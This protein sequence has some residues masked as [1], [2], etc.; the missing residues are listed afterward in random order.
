METIIERSSMNKKLAILAASGWILSAVLALEL[1][2][3][4]ADFKSAY[5]ELRSRDEIF[6]TAKQIVT[7]IKFQEI[8]DNNKDM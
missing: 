5:D 3:L 4:S 1:K 8:V 7:E 6:E 2:K